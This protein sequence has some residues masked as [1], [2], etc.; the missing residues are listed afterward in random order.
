MADLGYNILYAALLGDQ[1]QKQVFLVKA[2]SSNKSIHLVQVFFFK[3]GCIRGISVEYHD[4]VQMS[5]KVIAAFLALFY[6]LYGNAEFSQFS[7]KVV[8]G[9]SAAYNHNLLEVCVFSSFVNLLVQLDDFRFF[10][11]QIKGVVLINDGFAVRN[12]D[13]AVS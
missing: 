1:C 7:C 5:G 4:I 2:R 8:S 9:L 11:N 3:K 13:F 12:D 10:S 6:N